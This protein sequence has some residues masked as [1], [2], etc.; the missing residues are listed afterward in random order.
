MTTNVNN[1]LLSQTN[2]RP[3]SVVPLSS[4]PSTLSFALMVPSV[5]IVVSI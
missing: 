1:T 4:T 2:N 5:A 3:A